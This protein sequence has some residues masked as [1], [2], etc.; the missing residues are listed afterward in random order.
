M[1]VDTLVCLLLVLGVA[2]GL[3]RIVVDRL[4]FTPAESLVAGSAL[5]LI[6]AW[7]IAWVIFIS[8]ADL[9]AYRLVPIAAAVGLVAGRRSAVRVLLD[10]EARDL[11]AGQLIV[12][13]WCVACLSFVK[14]HIPA[15]P[16]SGTG[17]SIGSGRISS[18]ATGRPTSSSSTSLSRS[19]RALPSR[20]S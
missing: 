9:S 15:A 2:F 4:G 19:R 7:A 12:T 11:A 1:I 5:S 16:G 13:A 10:P 18:C 20:I 17:W 6:G 3:S 8:G 14:V